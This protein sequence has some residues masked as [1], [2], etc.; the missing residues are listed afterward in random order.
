MNQMTTKV[1][2]T[3][4]S[5]VPALGESWGHACTNRVILYWSGASRQAYLA[6]SPS[7]RACTAAYAIAATGLVAAP[8][9]PHPNPDATP[10]PLPHMH[11][12]N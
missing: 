12:S 10:P 2:P 1:D 8:A 4:A 3:G 9:P 7:Q 11:T 6:K 5:L